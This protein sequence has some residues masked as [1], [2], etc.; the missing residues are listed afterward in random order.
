VVGLRLALLGKAQVV[1]DGAPLT[2]WTLQK[3]LALLSYLAVT[4]R[5]H[6]REALAGLLWPDDTEANARASLRKV[7]AELR[8]R[9]PAHL[10]I[11]RTEVAFDG[12][13]NYWLDVEA[14]ERAIHRVLALPQS[15]VTRAGAAALAEAVE[16][17]RE[18][19]LS[20]LAVHHA[21]AFEEWVL[22]EQEY[23]RF[24]A[25]RALHALVD[26]HAAQAQPA[27][28]LAW[29]D[30]LL[31]LE[32]A[33]EE[34][35][36]H[37]MVLLVLSGQ[38]AAALRQ[39]EACRQALQA[40]DVEPDGETTALYRRIRNGVETPVPREARAPAHSLRA[41]LTP[42]V[43]REAELAEIRAR[44]R[45]PDCRLLTLLG[46]GGVGK[47]H[48]ALKVAADMLS[49]GPLD[50]FADGVSVAHLGS[51]PAVEAIAPAIA[52]ALDLPLSEGA[53]PLQQVVDSLYGKQLLLVI[54]GFEH[55]LAGAGLL[56]QLLEAVPGLKILATSR[57]RL[58]VEGEHLL[59]IRGLAC[60]VPTEIPLA[61]LPQRC[62]EGVPGD[63][64]AL[65]S[66]PA[67]RL[68]M[69]SA[70][71]ILPDFE[72]TGAELV[73]TARI[74]HLVGGRPLAILLAAGWAGMLTPAEIAAELEGEGGRGLDL[75]QTD[76]PDLPLRQRSMRAV[77][78]R[79]WGLLAAPERQVLAAL[80]VFRGSFALDAARQVAGASLRALRVL[81]DRS[82]LQRA[83]AE[84]YAMHELLRQYA[85]ERLAAAPGAAQEAHDRH[86]AYFATALERW[87]ADLQGPRHQPAL[88]EVGAESGNLRAAWD[89]AVERGQAA[90][91]DRAMEGLCYSYKWLGRYEEGES[92]CRQ[93]VEGLAAAAELGP[94][95][96]HGPS[97]VPPAAEA[98]ER[99]R[100]LARAM[101][102]QGVFCYRLGRRERAWELLQ[103][104]LD[105]LDGLAWTGPEGADG[106]R[107]EIQRGRAFVLWRLGNLASELDREAAPRLHRQSLALYRALEDPW[108]TASV[109]EASGRTATFSGERDRAQHAYAESLELRQ[110]QGDELGSYRVLSLSLT[111]AAHQGRA[112]GERSESQGTMGPALHEVGLAIGAGQFAR[113][114]SLLA[115]R[116]STGEKPGAGGSVGLLD[117]VR[118][119]NQMHLGHYDRARA[120]TMACLARFRETGYR[121]G[122]ERC[123]CYLALVVLATGAYGEAQQWLEESV[124]L[125]QEI[126]QRGHLGQ[127]LAL[128]ALIA[129]GSGDLPQARQHLYE[130]LRVAAPVHDYETFMFRIIVVSTMA[131][132]LAD[133]GQLERAVELYA[134]AS[135]YPLVANSRL[136]EDL[137]GQQ[138]AAIAA[139]LLPDS[140]AA[141]QARGRARDL[142]AAVADLVAELGA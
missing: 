109:L 27:R 138:I 33:Q 137:V 15:P 102:W 35:H 66:S 115:Q 50:C 111:T 30:C 34:A 48:L 133:E 58:D 44:L 70:R 108:G 76:R 2:D 134:V 121:W 67:V 104:S 93:A 107:Q 122:I 100:V 61:G 78:D 99:L 11:T 71:R 141:A 105:L 47:T 36:R 96:S 87:W 74:C 42:L 129:R 113:A 41:P 49:A 21:P 52:Q 59:P 117:L 118:A 77:F 131:L 142:A 112:E 46:P 86:S 73:D 40:L 8:Q 28:T 16:L 75:L 26:Y 101:A 51:L 37:K 88:A 90:L 135:R 125:C 20:G 60:G 68:F 140:V 43:G 62:P 83:A 39:Y 17:Y 45:D 81:M 116:R 10:T 127:A 65:A 126:G 132:L 98:A 24:L 25:L 136:V 6:S 79:S 3:S 7:L 72:V 23:L 57:A 80:S 92:L 5:P 94:E 110:A 97:G 89:W 1:C 124:G 85:E 38:R 123:C 120:Q 18:G 119:F 14:F 31:A 114:E 84:R 106:L 69:S 64:A 12:T 139:Q 95:E 91:L 63:R 22:L 13:S 29:L 82:L 55:L 54:D 19:F 103:H 32:P 56:V 4:G 9:L 53:H 130:A 128:L